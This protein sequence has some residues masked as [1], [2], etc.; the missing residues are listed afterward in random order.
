MKIFRGSLKSLRRNPPAG[1]HAM[2]IGNFD[3]IH[4]GHQF[5]LRRL[6]EISREMKIPSLLL[7]FDPHPLFFLSPD[8][9]FRMIMSQK[10]KEEVLS[11]LGLDILSVL[12]FDKEV[13]NL[14]PEEFAL[15]VLW[16]LFH[17]SSLIV[18]EGF[19]FG[20]GRSGSIEDLWRILSP[21]G[22][23]VSS[24]PP[25]EEQG[26]RVSSSRIRKAVDHGE[27]EEAN[28]L[29]TRPIEISGP[30]SEG[31]KRGRLLGFPTLNLIPPDHR[32]IP[33]PGVYATRTQIAGKTYDGATYIGTKPTFG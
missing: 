20:H 21:L 10:E 22:A 3:G 1:P 2:T 11:E 31:E 24:I 23:E 25:Y 17:P 28:R 4:A 26:V 32:L 15:S 7:T 33:P 18:G 29:L 14:S 19:R 9:P 27:I 6:F 12:T 30:V 5:L 8:T 16:D 13:Q